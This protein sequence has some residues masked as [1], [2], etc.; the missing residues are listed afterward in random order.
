MRLS[1]FRGSMVLM[2]A[3]AAECEV[4]VEIVLAVECAVPVAGAAGWGFA[5]LKSQ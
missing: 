4:V 5:E 3:V 1:N 2:G